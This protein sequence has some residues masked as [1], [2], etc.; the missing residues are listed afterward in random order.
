MN[1]KSNQN[2]KGLLLVL[3][4]FLLTFNIWHAAKHGLWYGF[5]KP[6]AQ[7]YTITATGGAKIDGQTW[8]RVK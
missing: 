2:F 8:F 5:L 3:F 4:A 1:D 7:T 6:T